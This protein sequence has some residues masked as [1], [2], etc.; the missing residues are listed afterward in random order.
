MS[1]QDPIAD[2]LT[3]I[4]N[5]QNANKIFV[6]VPFSK[7]KE[8]IIKVLK[9]E[10]YIG[11]YKIQNIK[12][13]QLKIFLKYF[14]GKSVIEH[15]SRVS[16]PGLR[17]YCKKYKLPVVMNNLGIAIISTSRG[18]MTDRIARQKGLGGEV[19]CYVD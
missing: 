5:G 10:G 12:I 7:M 11:S 16:R 9:Y 1:M 17:K 8:N 4:R 6:V 19:I 3:C 14:N 18:I 13:I 2:M 15:I